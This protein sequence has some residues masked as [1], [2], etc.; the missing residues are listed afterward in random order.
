MYHYTSSYCLSRQPDSQFQNVDI[1]AVEMSFLYLNYTKIYVVLAY[2]FSINPVYIDLN[3][4]KHKYINSSMLLSNFISSIPDGTLTSIDPSYLKNKINYVKYGDAAQAGYKV[5][6]DNINLSL[7]RGSEDLT[8]LNNT[9]LLTVNGYIHASSV[10]NGSVNI[11]NGFLSAKRTQSMNVG[12][13]T[14]A[15][16][17]VITKTPISQG[18]LNLDPGTDPLSL[19]Y[20]QANVDDTRN[21]FMLSLGGYLLTQ[22]DNLFWYMGNGIFALSLNNFGYQNKLIESY[23]YIDMGNVNNLYDAQ[24]NIDMSVASQYSN[25]INYITNPNTFIISIPAKNTVIKKLNVIK[26]PLFNSFI[27]YTP[28][29]NPLFT[30]EGRMVDYYYIEEDGRYLVSSTNL[31]SDNYNILSLGSNST[32]NI[33]QKRNPSNPILKRME[34]KQYGFY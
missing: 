10:V 11:A 26:T 18:N 31:S 29:N 20:I 3:I 17:G 8:L 6:G 14:F 1:S 2:D 34:F 19:L 27:E 30:G 32:G 22:Q 9:S 15:D 23:K 7:S 13:L 28:P 12:I 4:F 25:I 16:V 5:S 24:G 33:D 21:V